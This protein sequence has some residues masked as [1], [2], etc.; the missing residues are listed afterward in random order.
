MPITPARMPFFE[1]LAELR[2]R[3]FIVIGVVA[4][5]SLA[6]YGFAWNI[7]DFV[8]APVLPYLKDAGVTQLNVLGPFGG[9]TLRFKVAMYA[10]LVVA[11]PIIIWQT[12]AF[13]LP[14][15]KPRERRYVVPTFFS[16][17]ALFA[18]GIVFCYL[19]VEPAAFQWMIGQVDSTTLGV[20][21][22]AALWFQAV[23]LLLLAFGIGFQL[24]VIVFYLL[25]FNVISYKKL[26][27][28]WRVAY[29][30]MMCV[31]A[32]A[33]PDWSPVTMGALFGALVLLYEASMLLSRA[34]LS[35]R[36]RAQKRREELED[37]GLS[38]EEI[39]QALAKG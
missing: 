33:T 36:I 32:V 31:A 23:T 26:R 11:S 21:P 29:V 2:Q 14:A 3:L 34:V 27:Q 35:R 24:P 5:A 10:S 15:L 39:E 28:S 37:Q 25:I 7:Y 9:F 6:L 16:M 18:A 30:I 1:H 17:V 20:L 19:I 4:V 12:M 38:P 13:F 22:D 8:L